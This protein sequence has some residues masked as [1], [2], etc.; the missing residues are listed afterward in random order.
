MKIIRLNKIGQAQT[1]AP[2]I[3]F[4]QG[5][6]VIFVDP[7]TGKETT[8]V[9]DAI[10]PNGMPR[11]N[12][13]FL[14][15]GMIRVVEPQSLRKLDLSGLKSGDKFEVPPAIYPPSENPNIFLSWLPNGFADAI[16]GSR[17][18]VQVSKGSIK[19]L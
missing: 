5:E 6:E 14:G 16:S 8:G 15:S 1:T 7:K 2:K 17:R 4:K 13:G 9:F 12:I 11:V 19:P 18:K 10:H 3:E